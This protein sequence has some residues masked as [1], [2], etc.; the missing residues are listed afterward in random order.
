M[1]LHEAWAW[2]PAKQLFRCSSNLGVASLANSSIT[3]SEDSLGVI[4]FVAWR[5]ADRAFDTGDRVLVA[6]SRTT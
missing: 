3:F 5:I 2:Y 4:F 1:R 6:S